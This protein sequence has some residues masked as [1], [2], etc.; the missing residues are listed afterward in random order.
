ME[1]FLFAKGSSG[2]FRQ[3]ALHQLDETVGSITF[4]LV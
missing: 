4:S 3:K 2:L 1:T